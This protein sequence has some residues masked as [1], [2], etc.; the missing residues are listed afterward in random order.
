MSFSLGKK[1]KMYSRD[2]DKSDYSSPFTGETRRKQDE[3]RNKPD[4]EYKQEMESKYGFKSKGNSFYDSLQR[5]YKEKG[6]LTEKQIEAAKS[7]IIRPSRNYDSDL[8]REFMM[9][10]DFGSQ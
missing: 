8:D 5:Q 3:L 9:A 10:N 6:F 7:S 2:D 1:N 4:Y